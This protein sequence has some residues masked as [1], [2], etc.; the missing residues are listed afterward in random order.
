[1]KI[2][3]ITLFGDNYG[4]KLQNLAVQKLFESKGCEVETI[5]VKVEN[6]IIKPTS[7]KHKL[8]KLNPLYIIKVL[9]QRF[10]NKY[11]YKNSRDGIIKSVIFVKKTKEFLSGFLI[12]ISAFLIPF[13]SFIIF[14]CFME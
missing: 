4:N 7:L 1:M 6:G 10:K 8:K 9:K 13:C 14:S 5:I 3:I 2:G 12:T 11:H